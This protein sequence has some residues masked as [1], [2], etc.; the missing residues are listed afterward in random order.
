MKKISIILMFI[1][2]CFAFV[3]C[4]SGSFDSENF[5]MRDSV[6]KNDGIKNLIKALDNNDKNSLKKLFAPNAIAAD[7][8]FEQTLDELFEY[9]D[10]SVVS[11]D[12]YVQP[13]VYES[14]EDGNIQKIHEF[15]HDVVTDVRTYR[16]C[17]RQCVYDIDESDNEGISCLYIIK[18]EDDESD[19]KYRGD[20]LYTPGIHIGVP[21]SDID[22]DYAP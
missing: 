4:E 11:Y 18:A 1:C 22:V 5:L 10:G 21:N 17:V 6:G 13:A 15:S 12:D 14:S 3:A 19:Y 2:I 8:D 16:I 7:E 20:R 9:Y